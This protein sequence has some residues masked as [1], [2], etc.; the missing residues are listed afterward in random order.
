MSDSGY[1]KVCERF[2]PGYEKYNSICAYCGKRYGHHFGFHD[3]PTCERHNDYELYKPNSGVKR[4]TMGTYTN[5]L[6]KGTRVRW[7]IGTKYWTCTVVDQKD[8][9]HSGFI[10]IRVDSEFLQYNTLDDKHSAHESDLEVLSQ[11]PEHKDFKLGDRVEVIYFD[12][13]NIRTS[14]A[15]V[16]H[17]GGSS[18]TTMLDTPWVGA[19]ADPWPLHMNVEKKDLEYAKSLGFSEKSFQEKRSWSVAQ[20]NEISFITRILGSVK[21]TENKTEKETMSQVDVSKLNKGDRVLITVKDREGFPYT[22]EATVLFYDS[23]YGEV[24]VYFDR[25]IA[26]AGGVVSYLPASVGPVSEQICRD[27]KLD[28]S[29]PHMLK[30][31]STNNQVRIMRVI[32]KADKKDSEK[33]DTGK[34]KDMTEKKESTGIVAMMKS[35]AEKMVWRSAAT[36]FS[37]AMQGAILL[38]MKS[39]MEES[40]VAVLQEFLGTDFGNAIIRIFLGYGATYVPGFNQDPRVK[41]IAEE[42][43]VSGMTKVSDEVLGTLFTYLMPAFTE[44][45]KNLPPIQEA[46]PAALKPK[47]SRKRVSA[48]K[49]V[50]VENNPEIPVHE[51]AE[52]AAEAEAATA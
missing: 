4:F 43:R 26:F 15:T 49:R 16:V 24:H 11:P 38:A 10:G 9:K 40:K 42:F 7:N 47:A 28:F 32:S 34:E 30:F 8:A 29:K 19:N 48:N 18:I 50:A 14:I 17:L 23:G 31:A 37:N 44:A 51:A 12:K 35:D 25:Q 33:K 13:E 46:V 21:P 45:V 36:Q 5:L 22:E 41:R 39:Q 1:N 6:K 2:G 52:E 20:A 27:L 3:D